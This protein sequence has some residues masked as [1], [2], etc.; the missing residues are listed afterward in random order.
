MALTWHRIVLPKDDDTSRFLKMGE[1][2]LFTGLLQPGIS[3][4]RSDSGV[5][6]AS[7][8]QTTPTYSQRSS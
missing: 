8:V 6:L 4:W 2:L 5:A 1:R 7:E 3:I